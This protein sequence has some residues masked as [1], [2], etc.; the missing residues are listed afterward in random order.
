MDPVDRLNQTVNKIEMDRATY[1]AEMSDSAAVVKAINDYYDTKLR[2]A[3][4]WYRARVSAAEAQ[5]EQPI[6]MCR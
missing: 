3:H 6:T 2:L 5:K 4:A 1:T